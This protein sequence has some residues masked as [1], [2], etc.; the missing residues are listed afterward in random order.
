[1]DTAT[2]LINVINALGLSV[3]ARP[4]CPT[5]FRFSPRCF[6]SWALIESNFGGVGAPAIGDESLNRR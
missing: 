5:H 2:T 3:S 6:V 1:M 4:I